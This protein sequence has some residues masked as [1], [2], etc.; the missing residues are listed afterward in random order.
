MTSTDQARVVLVTGGTR[1]LGR[2]L[3]CSFLE[4]GSTVVVCGRSKPDALA[5][6]EGT[7]AEF[8]EC[9]VRNPEQ[10]ASMIETVVAD[11]GR[12]DVLVNN[13]GGAPPAEA[14]TVSP[15]FHAGIIELNLTGPLHC[16][17]AANRVMQAQAAG[18]V[19]IN[20]ASISG[21]RPSPGTA[22]Y[23]AAKAGIINLSQSLA[24]EWAPKVRVNTVVPGLLRTE[25]VAVHYGDE[26]GQR[27]VAE[28]IPL[29]RLI[30]PSEVGAV[31]VF[32]ASDAAGAVTGASIEVHGGGERPSFLNAAS[33][34]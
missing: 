27:R 19:I 2:G 1:G 18:G 24:V 33:A 8:V 7:L 17:Q 20:I 34:D 12:L 11:H 26:D 31:C 21:Q 30:E 5:E 14:A 15:R 28:T 22:A 6:W 16:A 32:L 3:A 4:A 23:G 13:A 29:G 25:N 10:V 9:D